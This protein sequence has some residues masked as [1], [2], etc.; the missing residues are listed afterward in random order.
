[1][2]LNYSPELPKL[3]TDCRGTL[4]IQL[5][6]FPTHYLVLVVTAERF[7]YAL[8]TTKV[9]TESMYNNMTLEDIAWLDFDRIHDASV[10]R[11][12]AD[13]LPNVQGSPDEPNP[14]IKRSYG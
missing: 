8:I 3:G 14:T 10:V 4:Y 6:N 5:A 1:M 12:D 9:Q 11:N 7:K 2:L 13:R